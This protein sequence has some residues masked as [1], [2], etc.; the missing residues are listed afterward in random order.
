MKE[1]CVTLVGVLREEKGFYGPP[2]DD[3]TRLC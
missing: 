3:L 2:V 1:C